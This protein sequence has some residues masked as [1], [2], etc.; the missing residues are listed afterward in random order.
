MVSKDGRR[1]GN[2]PVFVKFKMF[3]KTKKYSTIRGN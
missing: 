2:M 3:S 1:K